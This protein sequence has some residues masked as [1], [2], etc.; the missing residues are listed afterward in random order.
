MGIRQVASLLDLY[1]L[2]VGLGLKQDP[3]AWKNLINPAKITELE[4]RVKNLK[5][6]IDNT[7]K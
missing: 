7:S 4:E 3:D 2:G 5:N 6:S 1:I